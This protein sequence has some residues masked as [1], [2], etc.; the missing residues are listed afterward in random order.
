M[1]NYNEKNISGTKRTRCYKIEIMNPYN[2]RQIAVFHEEDIH[3]IGDEQ[4]SKK[5]G[6]ITILVDPDKEV[7]HP[8]SGKKMTYGDLYQWV[9]AA[10]LQEALE[11][12]ALK[13]A[14]AD[15]SEDDEIDE[16]PEEESNND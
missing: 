16:G 15:E 8:E 14:V 7:T 12:D 9:G 10:Y 5:V 11:R 2:D 13:N 6:A 1:Q 3:Q 4:I